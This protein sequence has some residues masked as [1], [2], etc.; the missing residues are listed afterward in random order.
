MGGGGGGVVGVEKPVQAGRE[1]RSVKG[2]EGWGQG[3]LR[4]GPETER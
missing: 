2:V 1:K 3:A 4:C